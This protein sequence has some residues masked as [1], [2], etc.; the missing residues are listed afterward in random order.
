MDGHRNV[1]YDRTTGK[2]DWAGDRFVQGADH[3]VVPASHQ[4][5]L[6]DLDRDSVLTNPMAIQNGADYTINDHYW[7]AEVN[8]VS[9]T[10]GPF[11]WTVGASHLDYVQSNYLN[12]LRYNN[13]ADVAGNGARPGPPH[14]PLLLS[15][16]R[17]HQ[18]R[19]VR[20]GRLPDHARRCRSRSACATTTTRSGFDP[21]SYS[22][23]GPFPAGRLSHYNAP[24]GRGVAGATCRTS[25]R[26]RAVCW[27][28]GSRPRITC[29]TAPSGEATSRAAPRRWPTPTIPRK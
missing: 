28:T 9:T 7:S 15:Q 19:G 4:H 2:L 1:D 10:A 3:A 24:T 5:Y 16:E 14:A 20:R 17:A 11:E 29:S 25:M 13:A 12:F 6:Q 22:S 23:A 18:Q 8:L 21:S 26:R 27:S